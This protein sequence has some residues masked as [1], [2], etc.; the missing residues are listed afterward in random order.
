MSESEILIC[1][2]K[3][4][5]E[6]LKEMSP[7]ELWENLEKQNKQLA[8]LGVKTPVSIIFFGASNHGFNYEDRRFPGGGV[9]PTPV[10]CLATVLHSEPKLRKKSTEEFEE[11]MGVVSRTSMMV[12]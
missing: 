6:Q 5:E 1:K 12:E 9:K 7:E 10:N 3:S 4:I 8:A 2:S 11:L